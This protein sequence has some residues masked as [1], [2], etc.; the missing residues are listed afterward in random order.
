MGKYFLDQKNE[1]TE[2]SKEESIPTYSEPEG[3]KQGVI[4]GAV[5]VKLK[6]NPDIS[7]ETV[8]VLVKGQKVLIRS[9]APTNGYTKVK[10]MDLRNVGY[11][12]DKYIKYI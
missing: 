2:Y 1:N 4:D 7:S 5:S 6:K 11:V 9:N 12:K 10:T 8:A 3:E